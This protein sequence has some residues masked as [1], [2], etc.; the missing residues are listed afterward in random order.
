MV[1]GYAP[2]CCIIVSGGDS[3]CMNLGSDDIIMIKT[4]AVHGF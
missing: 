1:F 2:A 3:G 4:G